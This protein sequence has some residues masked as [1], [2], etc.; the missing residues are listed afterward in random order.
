MSFGALAPGIST[1]P[2]TRSAVVDLLEN[3]VTI[4]V[5]QTQFAGITSD[6]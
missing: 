2:T 1:P 5:D 4:R 6:R 3:V